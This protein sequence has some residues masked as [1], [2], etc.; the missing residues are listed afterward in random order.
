MRP[1]KLWPSVQRSAEK[2]MLN[3]A[4]IASNSPESGVG[5]EEKNRAACSA[6][7]AERLK[8]RSGYSL[9]LTRT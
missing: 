6:C 2:K 4:A 7:D 1:H 9:L 5:R 3:A 8:M